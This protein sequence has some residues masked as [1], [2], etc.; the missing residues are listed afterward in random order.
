[1]DHCVV[2]RRP[3]IRRLFFGAFALVLVFVNTHAVA[4]E[5]PAA[6]SALPTQLQAKPN[7]CV[8]LHQGQVCYQ[9]VQLIWHA[10]QTGHYCIYQ[11]LAEAPLHCWQDAA[12]GEY[13][14]A[15]A[16]E[17]PVQLQLVNTRTKTPV[18]EITIEVAWVYKSSSRRKTHWRIF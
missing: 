10:G 15:F 17:V 1:M 12:A 3:P 14:Y 16:S 2:H 4:E 13:F 8:A 6:L 9:N 7:R 18:A 11:Q 5:K